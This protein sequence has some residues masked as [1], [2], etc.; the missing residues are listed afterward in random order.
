MKDKE[1]IKRVLAFYANR[2]GCNNPNGQS[3]FKTLYSKFCIAQQAKGGN[4][5]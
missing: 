2:Y 1:T 5:K 3:V 4:N